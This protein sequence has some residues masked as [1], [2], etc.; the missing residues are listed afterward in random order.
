MY[1]IPCIDGTLVENEGTLARL[2][3][4]KFCSLAAAEGFTVG[5]INDFQ[6][7][8]VERTGT[9]Y[10]LY[11]STLKLTKTKDDDDGYGDE[12]DPDD[13]A[14]SQD[15]SDDDK[16]DD[17]DDDDEEGRGDNSDADNFSE[18]H[19][20]DSD[21]SPVKRNEASKKK[22]DKGKSKLPIRSPSM[23]LVE[24]REKDTHLFTNRL[25]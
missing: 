3:N 24:K 22:K 20:S 23:T 13:E 16:G 11:P 5:I 6:V 19:G 21:E 9:K 10:P 2:I 18:S 25:N 14:M 4:S 15:N 8:W 1:A 12:G 17:D 7:P